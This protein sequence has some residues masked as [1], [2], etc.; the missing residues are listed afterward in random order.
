MHKSKLM[1][2]TAVA[3]AAIA[4]AAALTTPDVSYADNE[5][6]AYQMVV[7][8]DRRHGIK[9]TKGN[10]AK[11]IE[12][13]TSSPERRGEAFET[14]TNLCV[15]Y[16]KA[17]DLDNAVESCDAALA[18]IQQKERAL[19]ANG[20]ALMFE[21]YLALAL[22]NRGVLYAVDGD[23]DRA[24]SSFEAAMGLRAKLAAPK[25]NLAR[26]EQGAQSERI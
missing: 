18:Y 2:V 1:K 8:S 4:G 11:A 20:N 10:Y 3:V 6:A 25:G 22:S 23:V 5:A 16:T 26:L 17:G 15:A 14:R 13:I 9:V 19:T 7:F 12:R 24:R 21:R